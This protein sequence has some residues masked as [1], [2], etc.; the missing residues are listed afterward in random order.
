M[1]PTQK[2]QKGKGREWER[3]TKREKSKRH[4]APKWLSTGQVV[5]WPILK[6]WGGGKKKKE[7]KRT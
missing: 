3:I 7:K 5:S 2:Q 4:T 1:V 6:L